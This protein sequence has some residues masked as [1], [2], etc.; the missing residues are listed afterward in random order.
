MQGASEGDPRKDESSLK[1]HIITI[2]HFNS[3]G[4]AMSNWWPNGCVKITN[5]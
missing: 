5:M 4:D 2:V 3:L 1:F